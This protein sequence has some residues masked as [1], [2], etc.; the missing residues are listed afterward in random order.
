[1]L[2]VQ[3]TTYLI[4]CQNFQHSPSC[5]ASTRQTRRHLPKAIKK[6]V[7]CLAK[8]LQV[9]SES[10]EFGASGHC[11][12]IC[13]NCPYNLTFLSYITYLTFFNCFTHLTCL[14]C[15]KHL[16][17]D[18]CFKNLFFYL[19]YLFYP[20]YLFCSSYQSYLPLHLKNIFRKLKVIFSVYLEIKNS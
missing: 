16:T 3:K 6:N 7:S 17:C 5:L 2:F 10:R 9:L 19:S 8:L 20:C 4:L 11:L 1:M 12:S 18:T 14:N 13:L 15:L